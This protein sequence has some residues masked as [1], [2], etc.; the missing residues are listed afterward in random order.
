M[1][2][3]IASVAEGGMRRAPKSCGCE[4]PLISI[5]GRI[6]MSLSNV[7]LFGCHLPIQCRRSNLYWALLD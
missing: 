1:L 5:F 2:I 6:E 3:V 4:P 7:P